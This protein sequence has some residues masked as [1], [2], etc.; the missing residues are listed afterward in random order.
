M[1]TPELAARA[2]ADNEQLG[3]PEVPDELLE[4]IE[5]LE[6]QLATERDALSEAE[7]ERERGRKAASLKAEIADTK[8]RRKE[9]AALAACEAKYGLLGKAIGQVDTIDG[10]VI[11]KKP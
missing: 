1:T 9:E 7:A 3:R 11:V 2:A 5:V 10:M 8:R 4:E 6:R